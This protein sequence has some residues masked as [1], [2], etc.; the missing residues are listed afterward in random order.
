[1]TLAN[2]TVSFQIDVGAIID[3]QMVR[4]DYGVSGSPVW[5][6]PEDH[7]FADFVIDIAGVNVSIKALPIELRNAILECAIESCDDDKWSG[8]D[9]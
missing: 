4:S 6:Q 7:D 2:Q 8:Y 3:A 9:D 1:M 5:Y